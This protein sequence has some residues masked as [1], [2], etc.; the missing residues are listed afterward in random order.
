MIR[1]ER[2]AGGLTGTA[3]VAAARMGRRCAYAGCLGDDELSC[4]IL[5]GL[6]AEGVD[7][8]A[9][10]HRP[11]ARPFHSTILVDLKA[12]TRTILSDASGVIGADPSGLAEALVRSAKVLFVDHVGLGVMVRASRLARESGIPVVADFDRRFEAPFD[13]LLALVDHLVVPLEFARQITGAPDAVAAVLG[14]WNDGRS[15]VVVTD[16]TAGSWYA[17]RELPGRVFHQPAFRVEAMD[18]NGC[19]DVFHGCYAAGLCEGWPIEGRVR[20]ASA[21]AAIKATRRGGQQGIPSKADADLF[22]ADRSA[23]A[24]PR[25]VA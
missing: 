11:D 4:F 13:E 22:L 14:L 23:E 2:H 18:T 17:S 5:D 3:L 7:T 24:L 21:V 8:A 15:A 25:E 1:R 12:L 10:V 16:G 9:V 20:F 6:A 19:G